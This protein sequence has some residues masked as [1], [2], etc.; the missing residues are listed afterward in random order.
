MLEC[1]IKLMTMAYSGN[2]HYLFFQCISW[3]RITIKITQLKDIY[4]GAQKNR[5][6]H[7]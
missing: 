1:F 3:K 7:N 5:K 4:V 2:P 6:I